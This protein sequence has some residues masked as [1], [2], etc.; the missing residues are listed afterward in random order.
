MTIPIAL[1][2]D[3]RGY[4]IAPVPMRFSL[5]YQGRARKPR[6]MN[7]G[8]LPALGKGDSAGI[9]VHRSH[10]P[11]W[12]RGQGHQAGSR[13]ESAALGGGAGAFVDEPLSPEAR[14]GFDKKPENY[15]AFLHFACGLIA[16]RAAGLFG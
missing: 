14:F 8:A 1:A 5:F 12:S 15:L 4:L 11:A 9:W 7:A 3:A 6:G 16:L 2:G 13:V 10:S